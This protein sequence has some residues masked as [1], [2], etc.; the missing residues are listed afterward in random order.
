MLSAL[1][2][3]NTERI[4]NIMKVI[5]CNNKEEMSLAGAREIQECINQKPDCVLGLATG[6]TPLGMYENL[7]KMY[8]EG[9]LDFSKV[10]TFNLD[11]YCNLDVSDKNS[12]H[13]FMYENLFSKINVEKE[14]IHIPDGESKDADKECIDYE[15]AIVEAGGIDLQVLGIGRNGHIGFNEPDQ[16]LYKDTHVTD[17]TQTTIDDNARFFEKK[18]DVPTQAITMGMG[19]IMNA[20]KIIVLANG[21]GKKDAIRALLSG[22]VTTQ[23]P[24][25]LLQLHTN[26]VLICDK[27]AYPN[28]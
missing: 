22:K 20:R 12:Y 2:G 7:C 28:D 14:N 15:K 1:K 3:K 17:L 21:E 10:K 23:V 18:E 4:D 25:S 19:T 8:K 27:E 6:S 24:V 13:T 16:M 9:V 26:V 11:E 5:V